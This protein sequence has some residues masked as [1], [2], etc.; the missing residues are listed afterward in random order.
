NFRRLFDSRDEMTKLIGDAVVAC[1][2]PITAKTAVEQGL[3][4]TITAARNTIPALVEAV[5]Q[6]CSRPAARRS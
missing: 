6:Y 4:V 2:G 1:I 3:P 5:V